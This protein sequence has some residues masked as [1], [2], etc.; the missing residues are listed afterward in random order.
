[1]ESNAILNF[2]AEPLDTGLPEPTSDTPRVPS[3]RKKPNHVGVAMNDQG[4]QAGGLRVHTGAEPSDEA[5]AGQSVRLAELRAA[6]D[7]IREIRRFTNRGADAGA[8]PAE[9]ERRRLL[10]TVSLLLEAEGI[11]PRQPP[12]RP[13]SRCGLATAQAKGTVSGWCWCAGSGRGGVARATRNKNTSGGARRYCD[14]GASRPWWSVAPADAATWRSKPAPTE[15]RPPDPATCRWSG[16]R[17]VG[18][19]RCGRCHRPGW[20]APRGAGPAGEADLLCASDAG[21]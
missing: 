8:R 10:H 17:G 4:S 2:G 19:R 5:E 12:V 16:K 6:L 3:W 18:R 9:W 20:G 11:P 1:M 15:G 13:A 7:G 21:A 14:A